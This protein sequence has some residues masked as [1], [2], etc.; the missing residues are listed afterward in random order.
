MLYLSKKRVLFVSEAS[1]AGT[2][3]GRLYYELISRIYKSNKYEIA[4]F[5]SFCNVNDP[6]DQKI[7]WKLYANNVLPNDPRS[8]LFESNGNNKTGLWRFD[9]VLLD[10]RPDIVID[11]RDTPMCAYQGSSVNREYFHWCVCPTVDSAPQHI[12][13]ISS[14]ASADS[15]LTYSQFGFDVL[16]KLNLDLPLI[17]PVWFGVNHEDF[18]PV[19]QKQARGILG[20]PDNKFIVGSVMRNQQR[21]FIPDLISTISSIDNKNVVLYIHTTYPDLQAWGMQQCLLENNAYDR[22]YFSYVCQVCNHTFAS[23]WH[24]DKLMCPHCHNFSVIKPKVGQSASIQ[25][26][27][28]IYN[29][30][31]LYVQYANCE[32][33]G[34]GLLEAASAAI[35]IAAID[36]SAMSDLVHKL[37]GFPIPYLKLQ[38]DINTHADRAIPDNKHLANLISELNN[39]PSEILKKNGFDSMKLCREHFDWDKCAEIFINHID[40]IK[41]VGNQGKWS[42]STK[43]IIGDMPSKLQNEEAIDYVYRLLD[44]LNLDHIKYGD[45]IDKCIYFLDTHIFSTGGG[46]ETMTLDHI[47]NNIKNLQM[48]K[49]HYDNVRV[50]NIPNGHDFIDYAHIKEMSSV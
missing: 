3:F 16:N 22:V 8:K 34:I 42:T 30:F 11:I 31:D 38:K 9:D 10:F 6:R 7:K 4:E 18:Y 20:F 28:L 14:I 40:T 15:I 25:N 29:S 1:F 47:V 27:N 5:A 48:N 24:E 41:L 21:K 23:K 13:F 39:K 45:W 46:I 2:G 19:P 50:G 32:G 43:N 44:W 49:S 33:L 17:A 35:P 12:D 36:Y 37:N 26:L